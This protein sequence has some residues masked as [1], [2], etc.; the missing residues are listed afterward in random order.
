VPVTV[1]VCNECAGAKRL[2]RELGER[3]DAS[4]RSVGC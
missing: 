3:T 4:L 2:L 1:F